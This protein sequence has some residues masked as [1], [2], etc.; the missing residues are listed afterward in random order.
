MLSEMGL[1]EDIGLIKEITEYWPEYGD[2]DII[3][4]TTGDI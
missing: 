2:E 3:I 4:N 1:A